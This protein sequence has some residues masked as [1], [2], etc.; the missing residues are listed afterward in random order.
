MTATN[1]SGSDSADITVVVVDKPGPPKGPLLYS[2]TTHESVALSWGP[3]ADN[4]GASITNY[5]VEICDFGSDNWRQ[6]PGY[7]PTMG[8][9]ARGLSEGKR[10]MFR[11]RA[12]NLYGVSEPL[13]GKPVVAKSPFDPPGAPS[14]PEILGYT[15]NTC[16]LVWNPPEN[17]GGK[18]ITGKISPKA[19]S[20]HAQLILWFGY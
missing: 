1:D 19:K 12:E 10:Y 17:T 14:Q 20:S 2:G 9:T 16:T 8:F 4:G 3:P 5:I 7:C 15:P 13:D 18:P 6:V 11:V